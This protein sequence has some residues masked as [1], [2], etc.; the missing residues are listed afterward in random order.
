MIYLYQ[1]L[2]YKT[3]YG[4]S[5]S[6]SVWYNT[7]V[8]LDL[9]IAIKYKWRSPFTG[10]ICA[11]FSWPQLVSRMLFWF[12]GNT[13]LMRP[14]ISRRAVVW[15]IAQLR[16]AFHKTGIVV[17]IYMIFGLMVRLCTCLMPVLK[18]QNALNLSLPVCIAELLIMV[19]WALSFWVT[20]C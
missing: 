6:L 7:M 15:L 16:Y 3:I 17:I 14:D 18:S 8:D 11:V 19:I 5:L 12:W 10:T 2:L 9:Q 1:Y 4:M 20:A 13:S